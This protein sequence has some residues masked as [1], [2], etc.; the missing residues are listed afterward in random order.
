MA[1]RPGRIENLRPFAS[2]EKARE[3]GRKGGIASGVAKKNRKTLREHLKAILS[4]SIPKA[5]PLYTQL[6]NQ[7]KSLGIDGAPIVQDI[8]TLGMIKKAASS[9]QAAEFIRDTIGERP[10]ETFEDLTPQSPIMLGLIPADKVA[11]AKAEHDARQ[12]ENNEN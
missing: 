5:S 9:P 8:I 6:A 12:L 3:S 11:K 10:T 4:S 1:K 2:V 7:M